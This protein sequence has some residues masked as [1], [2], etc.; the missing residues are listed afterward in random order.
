LIIGLDQMDEGNNSLDLEVGQFGLSE[1]IDR[2]VGVFPPHKAGPVLVAT[3][4]NDKP[5]D[6]PTPRSLV[7][8][9]VGRRQ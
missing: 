1:F 9:F 7:R 6:R 3:C 4:C 8:F 5:I 2:S